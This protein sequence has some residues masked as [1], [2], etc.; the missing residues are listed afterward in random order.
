MLRAQQEAAEEKV[1]EEAVEEDT[2]VKVDF[3]E[4][5][6]ILCQEAMEQD[7]QDRDREPVAAVEDPVVGDAAVWTETKL[8]PELAENVSALHAARQFRIRPEPHVTH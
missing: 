8:E 7:Q 1:K 2:L 3:A 4:G 5:G 6:D